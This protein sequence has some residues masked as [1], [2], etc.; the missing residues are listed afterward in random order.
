MGLM[1]SSIQAQE[2]KIWEFSPYDV[3]IWYGFEPSVQLSDTAKQNFLRQVEQSL[4]RT[5]RATWRINLSPISPDLSR[6]ATRKFQDFTVEDLTADELVVVTALKHEQSKTIRTLEVALDKL[7]KFAIAPEHLE[8]L[9]QQS[10]RMQLSDDST[11]R[12]LIAKCETT[13]G[14]IPA[15]QESLGS[16]QIPAAVLP[17]SEVEPVRPDTRTL[18]TP[19]PWQSD[20][21]LQQRDKIFFL[22]IR[23]EGDHWVF[24]VREIDCPMQYVGPAFQAHTQFWNFGARSASRALVRAFAPIARVEDAETKTATLRLRAGGLVVSPQNPARVSVGD[25]MQPIVRRDDRNGIPT[26]LEPLSWTFAAVTATDGVKME[27]NVYSYSGGPGLQGRK[28]RRTRRVLLRVRPLVNQSDIKIAVRGKTDRAQAGCFVYQ[29]DLLTEEFELLGRTDWRGRFTIPVPK[30][31]GSFLPDAVRKE[32]YV[33]KKEA[34]KVA[35]AAR[36]A[37]EAAAK[38]GG[39]SEAE[40]I[41]AGKK[42]AS[43]IEI[44]AYDPTQDQDAIPLHFPLKQIYIKSG[45]TVLAKLPMVPGLRDIEVAELPD[46]SR[47]L[48]TEAFV[49]GFQGEILDLIGMRNLLAAK[50]K[51]YLADDQLELAKE[52]LDSL[53]ALKNYNEMADKLERIQQVMLDETKGPI[54]SNSLRRMDRMFQ[55]TREMLQKYLQDDLLRKAEQSVN[56]ASPDSESKEVAETEPVAA[57]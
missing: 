38:E 28:N 3:E 37:A 16:A 50:V 10:Q 41:E 55:T 9:Q 56:A 42:A 44:S 18:V 30:E 32:R 33:A 27:A 19:L 47:R 51:L 1:A 12:R 40:I 17:R 48:Q 13:A 23:L 2:V 14:G 11:T 25:V 39:A 21:Y 6:I 54:G 7:P 34:E 49:R 26:L 53:R 57:K 4:E 35:S 22:F 29:R 24:R 20:R 15:I 8:R 43:E 31:F 46:D 52:S 36:A 5:F 45:D